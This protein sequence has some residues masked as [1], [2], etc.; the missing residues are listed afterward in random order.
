MSRELVDLLEK[1]EAVADG[2]N[3]RDR[4]LVKKQHR[5]TRAKRRAWRGE[6]VEK[7]PEVLATAEVIEYPAATVPPP[8][9]SHAV[10]LVETPYSDEEIAERESQGR[11]RALLLQYRG[12]EP[13][14]E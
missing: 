1:H 7:V 6:P 4:D 9:S 2:K 11:L 5:E 10:E 8:P 13:A 3:L 14:T 12:E